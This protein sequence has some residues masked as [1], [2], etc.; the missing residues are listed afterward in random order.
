VSTL[1]RPR[2]GGQAAPVLSLDGRAAREQQSHYVCIPSA[3]REDQGCTALAMLGTVRVRAVLEQLRQHHGI[4]ASRSETQR[5]DTDW[6]TLS[7]CGGARVEQNARGFV[8][9]VLG[10][11]A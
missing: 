3:R 5:R 11:G 7:V 6:Q 9:S 4:A 2:G 10:R 1:G 8:V